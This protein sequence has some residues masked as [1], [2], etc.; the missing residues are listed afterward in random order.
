ML[1]DTFKVILLHGR[2]G[3]GKSETID[4]IKNTPVEQRKKLFHIGE[5]IA[6]DDFPMLWTWFEEDDILEQIGQKRLHTS[7]DGY[8]KGKYLWD[9][10]VRRLCLEYEKIIAEYP[11]GSA[12]TVIIEYARGKQHGGYKRAIENLTKKV[13]NDA[14]MFYVKVDFEESIRKNLKRKNP[15]M[16]HS[17]L[18]HSV[19]TEKLEFLYKDCDFA[20]VIADDEN[21]INAQ[22][23]KLP[24]VVLDNRKDLT[25]GPVANFGEILQE[26]FAKLWSN[27]N[28]NQG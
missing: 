22:G 3:S 27:Y 2:P 24:Y 6:I 18:E 8:F 26:H 1:R 15:D 5:F 14:A 23:M 28:P 17:I 12:P 19:E 21:F 7:P 10:L 20:E 16:L 9:L 11:E 13:I 25:S 4:F